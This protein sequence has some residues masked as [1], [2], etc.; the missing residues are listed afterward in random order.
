MEFIF[1]GT[2]AG[3]QYPGAWC[4]C[5]N[6][7]KARRLG[8][9]NIRK[10]S[11]AWLAPDTLL[12]FPYEIF[13]QSERFGVPV[14]DAKHL[15]F[16]HSHEDHFNPYMLAWRYM[17]ANVTQPPTKTIGA[18]RFSEIGLL[19]VYGNKQVCAGVNKY[20][21]K[22]MK[23]CNMEL[24]ELEPYRSYDLGQ[25]MHVTP[26][27]GNHSDQDGK[28]YNYIIEREDR[29]ILYALDTGWFLPETLAEI[30]EHRYDLAVVEGTFGYGAESEGHMNFRKLLLAHQLFVEHNLL[31]PGAEF[32]ATH[33]CPHWTPIHD[34]IAPAMAEKGITI[35]YDGMKVE[36][37]RL[38]SGT[39]CT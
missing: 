32:I 39:R 21:G 2:S 10:N 4:R 18:P 38:A 9:R 5:E 34:E 3:E 23:E 31:K 20:C 30:E 22:W 17:P 29:T 27:L 6:C 33:I 13:M 19:K 36:L 24:H 35:A 26:V 8:G 1:L 25:T 16:T 37:S 12:D 15:L 28:S 11:C 14:I 7:E